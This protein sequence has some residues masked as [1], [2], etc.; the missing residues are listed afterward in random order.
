MSSDESS[1]SDEMEINKESVEDA[2]VTVD[3]FVDC[4]FDVTT[5]EFDATDENVM[6]VSKAVEYV[7]KRDISDKH[8]D[9][10]I[11]GV[12]FKK[13]CNVKPPSMCNTG[14]YK[15]DY[16]YRL[17]FKQKGQEKD[18]EKS[19]FSKEIANLM[20]KREELRIPLKAKY[21]KTKNIDV[22]LIKARFF[23]LP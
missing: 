20:G 7:I 15:A 9:V 21:L 8:E 11:T 22:K 12:D 10:E 13:M 2:T 4:C 6:E 18:L 14:E 1:V 17:H 19:D 16:V 23:S 5:S 3:G